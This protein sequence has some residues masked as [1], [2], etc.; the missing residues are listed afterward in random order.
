MD[1]TSV[2]G[3]SRFAAE[4]ILVGVNGRGALG[5]TPSRVAGWTKNFR[6]AGRL[7]FRL[8]GAQPKSLVRV[9]MCA[10]LE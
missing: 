3:R 2:R 8:W 9:V 6:P 5:A 4:E 7:G 1:K 10:P